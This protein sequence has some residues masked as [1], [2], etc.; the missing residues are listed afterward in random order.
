MKRFAAVSLTAAALIAASLVPVSAA[1]AAPV[2]SV[3]SS[4][5]AM[6]A[7]ADAASPDPS[8]TPETP[9]PMMTT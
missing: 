6:F 9:P 5:D 1:A 2:N 7:E 8:A 4:V 3:V